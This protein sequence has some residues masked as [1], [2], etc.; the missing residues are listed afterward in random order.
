MTRGYK[1]THKGLPASGVVHDLECKECEY[2]EDEVF[3]CGTE[4]VQEEIRNLV[5]PQ[6]GEKEGF[7]NVYD[8]FRC[9]LNPNASSMYGKFWPSFGRVVNSYGEMKQL[10]KEYG[11][12]QAG[13]SVK[14]SKDPEYPER[15]NGPGQPL[16]DKI[17]VPERDSSGVIWGNTKEELQ[18]EMNNVTADLLS[19]ENL[20]REK[21]AQDREI[22]ERNS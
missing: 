10:C 2:R 11:V 7:R 18:K 13:D 19:P 6:C 22:S 21:K 17:K 1:I 20:A 3:L 8:N 5:C 16:S 15:Y 9:G 14:G 12:D 4:D